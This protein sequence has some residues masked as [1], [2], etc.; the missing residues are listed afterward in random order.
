M[1]TATLIVLLLLNVG[2]FAFWSYQN[3]KLVNK[4]MSR[5]YFEYEMSINQK[6]ENKRRQLKIQMPDEE[7]MN[8][9]DQTRIMDELTHRMI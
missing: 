7:E 9:P 3:Q 4:L 1:E 6:D 8:S 5:S 2:Q